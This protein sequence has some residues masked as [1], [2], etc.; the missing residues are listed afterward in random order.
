MYR[1]SGFAEKLNISN[2]VNLIVNFVH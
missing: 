2:C 1:M